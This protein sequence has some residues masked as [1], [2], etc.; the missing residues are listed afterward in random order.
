VKILTETEANLKEL[1]QG[2]EA[3][4]RELLQGGYMV[5]N[6]LT[7]VS[8]SASATSS[9]ATSFSAT[10]SRGARGLAPINTHMACL[11]K[12][13]WKMPGCDIWYGESV[14]LRMQTRCS[15]VAPLSYISR[16]GRSA[17]TRISRSPLPFQ[18]NH[19]RRL[20]LSGPTNCILYRA[21]FVVVCALPNAAVS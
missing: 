1:L 19:N 8:S 5:G 20:R 10:T 18:S 3:L 2:N 12:E 6:S 11:T 4:S 7:H 14:C 21:A 13:T 16:L 15:L 9:S 17:S